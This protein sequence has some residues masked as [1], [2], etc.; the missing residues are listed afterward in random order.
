MNRISPPPKK[1]SR[2]TKVSTV[3]TFGEREAKRKKKGK[4]TTEIDRNRT[5]GD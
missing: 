5:K 3:D 1:K 2:Q 4:R